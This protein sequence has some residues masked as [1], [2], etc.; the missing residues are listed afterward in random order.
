M[1]LDAGADATLHFNAPSEQP[2]FDGNT[3]LLFLI[4]CQNIQL[5]KIILEHESQQQHNRT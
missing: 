5:S 3:C 4:Q 1:L 2:L